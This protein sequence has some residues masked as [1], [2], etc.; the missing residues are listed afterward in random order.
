MPRVEQIEQVLIPCVK[1][2]RGMF[3]T[4]RLVTVR[5]KSGEMFPMFADYRSLVERNNRQYIR[6][7]RMEIDE[8]AG[9][10]VCLLPVAV[11]ETPSM[12]RWVW[13]PNNEILAL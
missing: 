9:F 2:S 6:V 10:S 13:V 7:T 3:E 8:E 4:E 5:D 11:T 1:T 12:T